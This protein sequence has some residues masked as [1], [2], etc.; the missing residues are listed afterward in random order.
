MMSILRQPPPASRSPRC[1]PSPQCVRLADFQGTTV[2]KNSHSVVLPRR[3]IAC[4][5]PT[6]TQLHPFFARYVLASVETPYLKIVRGFS[7]TQDFAAAPRGKS[8]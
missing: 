5:T 4:S 8:P 3:Y 1:A 6:P 2:A 7:S